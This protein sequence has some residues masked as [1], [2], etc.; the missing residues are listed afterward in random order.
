MQNIFNR[1]ERQ[2][3]LHESALQ[4]R[5][6]TGASLE[7]LNKF[8]DLIGFSLPTDFRQLYSWHDGCLNKV[9][10]SQINLFGKYRW[11]DLNE[12]STYW[13]SNAAYFNP[14]EPYFY[15]DSDGQ[16]DGLPIKPWQ[17]PPPYWIPIGRVVGD[18]NSLYFDMQPTS[19]GCVGQLVSQSVSSMSTS[20]FCDGL[21]QY[22]TSIVEGLENGTLKCV[23]NPNSDSMMWEHSDGTYFAP[24]GVRSVFG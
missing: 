14:V 3:A 16:W 5:M 9:N 23:K 21:P 19:N 12:V 10:P 15:D 4:I 17:S 8:E 1:L 6:Q 20:I 22:L 2:L 7:R 18:P 13:E 24:P 11:F